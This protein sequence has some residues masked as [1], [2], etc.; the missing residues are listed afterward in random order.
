MGKV[1]I[2]SQDKWLCSNHRYLSASAPIGSGGNMTTGWTS[3]F[4]RLFQ[5]Y[6]CY[7]GHRLC[8]SPSSVQILFQISL[9]HVRW[10]YKN[11][12][13]CFLPFTY[14][15]SSTFGTLN[16]TPTQKKANSL[17]WNGKV[18]CLRVFRFK[19]LHI[20]ADFGGRTVGTNQQCLNPGAVR[21]QGHHADLFN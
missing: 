10:I 17:T 16:V 2:H 7:L 20:L 6:L 19:T 11:T 13:H 15:F 14:P 5:R 4:K 18:C 21:R 1:G 8:L 12:F 3:K 9:Q